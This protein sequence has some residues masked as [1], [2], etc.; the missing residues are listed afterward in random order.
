[1]KNTKLLENTRRYRKTKKGLITNLF[2]KMK[3]RR[4]VS[5][6]KDDLYEFSKCSKFDRLFLEWE[7]SNYDK[8]Y[9]PS[10][11]R[12]NNKKGYDISNIH[13]LTWAEN[14]YKQTM[15]RRCRKGKVAMIMGDNVVK[16]F[17]SQREAVIHTGL[18][19]GNISSALNG[20]RKYCGGYKWEY[21]HE[22]KHL[23]K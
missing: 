9:K 16:I 3:S 8:Q 15:E 4:K 6:S 10:I 17:K 18:P 7:K 20:K 13:W 21:I 1:M 11:D 22:H 5:F 23:L 2:H 14:R 19:Q 12:I